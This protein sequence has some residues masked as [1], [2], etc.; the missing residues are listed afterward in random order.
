MT[1]RPS[2]RN[3]RRSA[4]DSGSSGVP[5]A[6]DG[7]ASEASEG[8]PDLDHLARR[9]KDSRPATPNPLSARAAARRRGASA[10]ARGRSRRESGR[11][12]QARSDAGNRSSRPRQKTIRTRARRTEFPETPLHDPRNQRLRF[13]QGLQGSRKRQEWDWGKEVREWLGWTSAEIVLAAAETD[14]FQRWMVPLCD[15]ID[16]DRKTYLYTA[17]EYELFLLWGRLEGQQTVS[18]TRTKLA[19]DEH[20]HDRRMLGFT[21]DRTWRGGY[22]R[23]RREGVPSNKAVCHHRKRLQPELRLEILRAVFEELLAQYLDAATLEELSVTYMDG[24]EMRTHYTPPRSGRLMRPS[25]AKPLDSRRMRPRGSDGRYVQDGDP[26]LCRRT[27]RAIGGG[28]RLRRSRRNWITCLDGGTSRDGNDGY[29]AVI[30]TNNAGIPLAYSLGPIQASEVGLAEPVIADLGEKVWSRTPQDVIPVMTTDA[31]FRSNEL[32]LKV[33]KAGAV[34]NIQH[35][36]SKE[37]SK[38]LVD[39]SRRQLIRIDRFRDWKANGLRELY[40]RCGEGVTYRRLRKLKSGEVSARIEGRCARCGPIELTAGEWRRQG[41]VEPR[42]VLAPIGLRDEER[43]MLG[44]PF[45]YNDKLSRHYRAQRMG[46][47]E[48]F[49]GALSKRFGVIRDAGWYRRQHDAEI[50]LLESFIPILVLAI[51]RKKMRA[52]QAMPVE[53]AGKPTVAERRRSQAARPPAR[54]G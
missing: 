16:A 9:L 45:T 41:Q 8:R 12:G 4:A 44:N 48:G 18:G 19:D 1:S 10:R 27:T 34:E 50:A 7:P 32:R 37:D 29:K 5:A 28:P 51:L 14:A 21:E 42:F 38:E 13:S 25:A 17:V 47:N 31:G 3:S 11:E 36:S 35:R 52:G 23:V 24:T 43:D 46:H 22:P 49:F 33:R 20:A 26:A 40:C 6:G 39:R 30:A 2:R 54:A 53:R 15:Q